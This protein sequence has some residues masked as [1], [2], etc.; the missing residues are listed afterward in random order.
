MLVVGF[1]GGALDAV[2][3]RW[4]KSDRDKHAGRRR[5]VPRY[6]YPGQDRIVLIVGSLLSQAKNFRQFG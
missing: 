5:Q 4:M 1:R 6:V 3:G 2:G